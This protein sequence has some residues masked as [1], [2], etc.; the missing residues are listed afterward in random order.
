MSNADKEPEIGILN[1][2]SSKL[3]HSLPNH[4]N[5]AV[6][7]HLTEY[8]KT[9]NFSEETIKA[10]IDHKARSQARELIDDLFNFVHHDQVEDP[11]NVTDAKL[12]EALLEAFHM[13]NVVDVKKNLLLILLSNIGIDKALLDAWLRDDILPE[14][15]KATVLGPIYQNL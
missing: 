9:T 13:D 6:S 4:I 7:K 8:I 14:E 15:L 11:K 12:M 1:V 2:Y 5:L 10:F 3:D